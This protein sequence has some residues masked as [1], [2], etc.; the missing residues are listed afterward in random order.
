MSRRGENIYKRKDGRWEGRYEK[1]RKENGAIKYGYVYSHSYHDVR[2]KLYS[3]K[4]KYQT[5]H[6][7]NGR[8]A[9][10]LVTWG[11]K[12]LSQ[13][14]ETVKPSTYA[15]YTHKLTTYI[16]PTIGDR[17]I[18]ELEVEELQQLV[19]QWKNQ[20]L[21]VSTIHVLYRVLNQCLKEAVKQELLTANPGTAV[22]LPRIKHRKVKALSITEQKHL[23]KAVQEYGSKLELPVLL[24]LYA[25]LRIGEIAALRWKDI[26]FEQG[27]IHIEHTYQ[28][29]GLAVEGKKT[30]LSFS[31]SKSEASVR[32][33]PL[34]MLLCRRLKK[35]QKEAVSPYVFQVNGKPCEPRLLT[36]HFHK[37]RKMASLEAIHFHQLR[38]TFATRCI[39]NHADIASVSALMGHASTQ[40]T[41]DTY[42]D[43]MM[44]QRF[45]IIYR[46]ERS[47]V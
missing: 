34:T 30:Q 42:A 18:N 36:Y 19:N 4:V 44:E 11:N 43:A 39:E 10:P 47:K 20:G 46:L 7:M 28:R 38:H 35:L 1:G 32:V 27:L 45:E 31:D 22:Q 21:S 33:V 3:L 16:Y 25:G 41:L 6:E 37:V 12:W 14:Q 2:H 13:I 24:A 17:P 15:S 9:M 40:M 5:L 29:I 8:S 23:E 26:D